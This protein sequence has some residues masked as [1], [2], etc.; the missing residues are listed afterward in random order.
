M[1]RIAVFSLSS[2]SHS[3]FSRRDRGMQT[4]TPRVT[5]HLTDFRRRACR[6][7]STT[8]RSRKKSIFEFKR[9]CENILSRN[10]PLFIRFL[11]IPLTSMLTLVVFGIFLLFYYFFS[12]LFGSV[13]ASLVWFDQTKRIETIRE[14]LVLVEC[15]TLAK[16]ITRN[17]LACVKVRCRQ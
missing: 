2:S 13:S 8:R 16:L 15:L 6:R 14:A 1:K 9:C 12:R 4:D 17:V 5:C 10:M 7:R 11:F 3:Q